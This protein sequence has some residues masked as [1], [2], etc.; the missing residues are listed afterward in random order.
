M[1]CESTSI[2]LGDLE[3]DKVSASLPGGRPISSWRERTCI[4][5][6][7]VLSRKLISRQSKE[8]SKGHLMAESKK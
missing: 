3:E 8:L 6:L 5:S 4:G 1:L 2:C 7:T